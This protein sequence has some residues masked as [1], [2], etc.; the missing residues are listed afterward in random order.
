VNSSD[1]ASGANEPDHH[2]LCALACW[3]TPLFVE[4]TT[5]SNES[6]II[7]SKK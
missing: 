3:N 4:L 5:G 2:P 1:D 7:S 6:I